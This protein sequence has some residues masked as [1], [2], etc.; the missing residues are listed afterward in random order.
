MALVFPKTLGR[1][2]RVAPLA[3][4]ALLSGCAQYHAKP[5]PAAPDLRAT[6][7][8]LIASPRELR[9]PGVHPRPFDP[10][11]GLSATQAAQ[12]A[13]VADPRLRALRRQRGLARAQ[14]FAAGL[15]PDPVFTLSAARVL[16][17][18]PGLYDPRALSLSEDLSR[19][20]TRGDA[21][22]AARAHAY[23]VD[24]D[25]LWAEWQVAAR[26]RM[27][28]TELRMDHRE[29]VLLK[30]ETRFYRTGIGAYRRAAAA[31][32]LTQIE[33]ARWHAALVR[34]QD[35]A[36]IVARRVLVAS[37][38]LRLLLGLA[39]TAPLPLQGAVHR[40]LPSPAAIA[41]ALKALPQRRPDLRALAA[42]YRSAD[43]RL[44]LQILAQFPGVSVQFSRGRDNNGID[45][46]GLAIGLRLPVFDGNRGRIA[47]ARA[48]RH[49]LRDHY[50]ARLDASTIGVQ[51]LY[52]VLRSLARE[53]RALGGTHLRHLRH[54]A[55][56]ARRAFQSGALDWDRYAVAQQYYFERA[57]L[58]LRVERKLAEGRVTLQTL[59]GVPGLRRTPT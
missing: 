38:D 25:V 50:Q 20:I 4:A 37:A 58:A 46:A 41:G 24:L 9:L 22:Q 51:R 28:W 59:L 27:L 52:Q 29:Q 48:T 3:V 56:R 42:G 33:L 39:N 36:G 26:A 44:R 45:S 32:A 12:F 1:G 8:S 7:P 5:L 10:R 6:L 55:A 11:L 43:A 2:S 18:G 57:Q 19:L 16:S 15:L 53:Q 34:V 14:L 40:A 49:A 23:Q 13:V 30:R 54:I 17:T 47:V 21:R 35:R 31:G